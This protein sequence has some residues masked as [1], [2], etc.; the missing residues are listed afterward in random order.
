[1]DYT[2]ALV[3]WAGA[4]FIIASMLLREQAPYHRLSDKIEKRWSEQGWPIHHKPVKVGYCGSEPHEAQQLVTQESGVLGVAGQRV[5]FARPHDPCAKFIELRA[6]LWIGAVT[7][8]PTSLLVLHH[9]Y[10]GRYLVSTFILRTDLIGPLLGAISQHS[11]LTPHQ[12]ENQRESF[13]P[14]TAQ[15]MAQDV[16]GQWQPFAADDALDQSGGRAASLGG[17]LFLAPDR[18]VYNGRTAI[19]LA[20][21][22]QVELYGQDGLQKLNPLNE[23]LLRIEYEQNDQHCAAGFL[24]R[25]G[26]EWAEALHARLNIPVEVHEGR[27][28]KES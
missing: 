9:E 21:I 28:K 3:F 27:K 5:I 11:G 18:L 16:Y 8:P 17:E 14:F 4:I 20:Q 25:F 15:R 24:V 1:M 7:F 12:L 23:E 13:G 19:Y 2:L 10:E 22:R 26:R 6:L